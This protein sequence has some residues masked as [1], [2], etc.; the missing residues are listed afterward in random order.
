MSEDLLNTLIEQNKELIQIGSV[1][2]QRLEFIAS[3]LSSI[4]NEILSKGS[5]AVEELGTIRRIS[6]E[7]ALNTNN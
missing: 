3:K 2:I 4:E 7:I 5:T 1:T 6:E